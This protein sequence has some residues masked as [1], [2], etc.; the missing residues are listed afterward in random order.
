MR[1]G[2][3]ITMMKRSQTPFGDTLG[4]TTG[5]VHRTELAR[6]GVRMLKGVAYRRIDDA[7]VHISAGEAQSVVAADTVVVCAGQISRRELPA[8]HVIGGAREAGELD[9][10][11]AFLEGAELG[12]RL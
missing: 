3:A 1:R 12:A 9:A 5:W 11:R 7:G 10:E 6:H 8:G 2:R 4:R